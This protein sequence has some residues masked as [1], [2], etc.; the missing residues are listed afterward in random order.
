MNE[1]TIRTIYKSKQAITQAFTDVAPRAVSHVIRLHKD[2]FIVKME[3]ALFIWLQDC[4]RKR[5]GVTTSRMQSQACSLY[6]KV[7]D[8][9]DVENK[10]DYKFNGSQGWLDNLRHRYDL[11]Q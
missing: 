5:L 2:P 1:S 4:Y 3:K 8:D 6:K 7:V 10:E 9:S 11:T